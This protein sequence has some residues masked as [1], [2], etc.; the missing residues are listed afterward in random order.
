MPLSDVNWLWLH[1]E[2]DQRYQYAGPVNW[3]NFIKRMAQLRPDLPRGDIEKAVKKIQEV[4]RW[5]YEFLLARGFNPNGHW[6]GWTK[7]EL[8]LINAGEYK[9]GEKEASIRRMRQEGFQYSCNVLALQASKVREIKQEQRQQAQLSPKQTRTLPVQTQTPTASLAPKQVPTVSE[10]QP[11]L[12][13]T[14]RHVAPA[15]Q[16]HSGENAQAPETIP[17][18]GPINTGESSTNSNKRRDGD[19]AV[20]LSETAI[21]ESPPA[22]T[23]GPSDDHVSSDDSD[24]GIPDEDRLAAAADIINFALPGSAYD[25]QVNGTIDGCL[26]LAPLFTYDILQEN[27]S[28]FPQFGLLGSLEDMGSKVYQNTN[29]P[30]ASFICG[31]QGSG[32]SHTTSC[33]LENALVPINDGKFASF[34][35]PLSAMVFAYDDFTGDGTGF[36]ISE[37][38]SLAASR[39]ELPRHYRA[40]KVTVLVSPS[41]PSITALYKKKPNVTVIPFKI[42]PASLTV[43][44]I[45]KLMAVDESGKMPLYLATLTR[46]LREIN[47]QFGGKFSYKAFKD[48]IAQYQFDPTQR[49]M[50]QLRL[51]LLES[52]LDLQGNAPQP[53]FKPGEITIM[54]MSCPFV[55]ANTAC[56]LFKIGL[57]HYLAS[58]IPGK[59]VVLDEAHKYM[60][61]VPGAKD[62][63]ADLIRLIR[64]QRH[65]GIRTIIAT[66]EPTLLTDLIPL[67][68]VA[69]IHRFS[70]PEWFTALKRHI[71]MS[72]QD[73]NVLLEDIEALKPGNALIYAP[74]AVVGYDEGDE[75]IKGTGRFLKVR[76]RNRITFDGG[77]SVLAV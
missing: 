4:D 62:L 51:D 18:S 8:L 17:S 5:S 43:N 69:V 6:I 11:I 16:A 71:S 46:I 25:F 42:D 34:L 53:K 29:V 14:E 75:I 65:K 24:G 26:E 2:F 63:K 13:A 41:N 32:K 22:L 76:I 19:L 77:R 9:K 3:N 20:T 48:K 74:N 1:H 31:L 15:S 23:E 67:C 58:N 54:D 72:G 10:P 28:D 33:M 56:I 50:L 57:E 66:Q 40:Q 73:R 37:A 52:F 35:T 59:M 36:N 45:L 55:N 12:T 60:L 27:F 61:D 47:V 38:T 49:C 44:T 7:F 30:F 64:L 70:S 39:P 68:D 21:P